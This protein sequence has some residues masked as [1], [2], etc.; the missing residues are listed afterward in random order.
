MSWLTEELYVNNK[1]GL[2]TGYIKWTFHK[3]HSSDPLYQVWCVAIALSS[4]NLAHILVNLWTILFGNCWLFLQLSQS[5]RIMSEQCFLL[6]WI[7]FVSFKVNR[8]IS[9]RK[10]RTALPGWW[11]Q[12]L[13]FIKHRH[14]MPKG[15]WRKWSSWLPTCVESPCHQG[16]QK[17]GMANS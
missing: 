16:R 9:L 4:T 17:P 1:Y 12:R 14:S 5:I 10:L 3:Q 7:F 8:F 6:T 11:C 15:K 2:L 13:P